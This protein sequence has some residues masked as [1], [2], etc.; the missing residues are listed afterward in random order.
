VP[1]QA[2]RTIA[3]IS[4]LR[5]QVIVPILAGLAPSRQ[6]HGQ[7]TALNPIDD[8]YEA[9]RLEMLALIEDLGIAT[10]AGIAA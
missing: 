9:L 6:G 2:A 4:V 3:G 8:H 5:D 10:H 7:P 1:E